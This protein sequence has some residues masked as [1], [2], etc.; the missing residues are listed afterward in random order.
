MIKHRSQPF[1]LCPNIPA[2]GTS[3]AGCAPFARR[4]ETKG[5]REALILKTA[6]SQGHPA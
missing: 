1:H 4:G 2:G 6:P 3:E 5:L